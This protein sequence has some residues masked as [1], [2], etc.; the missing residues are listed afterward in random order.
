VNVRRAV[1]AAV[2]AGVVAVATWAPVAADPPT[3][4][5]PTAAAYGAAWLATTVTPEGYVEDSNGDPAPGA[6]VGT[7]LALATAGVEE[8]VFERIVAWLEDDVDAYAVTDGADNAGRLGYLLLLSDAAGLDPTTFGGTNLVARLEATLGALEPG[9]YG[10]ASPTFDGVFRQGVALLGLASAGVT[11][12]ASAVDWLVDQ[13]CDGASPATA[14]GGWE[15]YRTDVGVPC[16]APDPLLFIGPDTNSSSLATQALALLGVTPDSDPLEFFEASQNDDG[17]FAYIPGDV[18]DPNST[19][20]VIQAIIAGGEDPAAAPWLAGGVSP[21]T[22]LLSWQLGCDEAV[23]DRGA[24]AS[25]FSDGAPDPFATSQAVLGAAE[26]AFPLGEVTF[27][28]APVPCQVAEP[29]T[30]TTVAPGDGA[31]GGARAA[32]VTPRFAG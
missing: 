14:V 24:F 30:T 32:A 7:A 15:A 17:G 5:P 31:S 25:P 6:T 11:P 9:L 12:A 4:D 16:S 19:G 29:T 18:S 26:R 23:P 20:L 10:V 27:T 3:N 28:E 2:A 1:S 22:S 13:Q 21:Y 8:G